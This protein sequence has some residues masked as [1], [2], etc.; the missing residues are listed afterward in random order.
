MLIL[1]YRFP[2]CLKFSDMQRYP[3][4]DKEKILM[5]QHRNHL[6]LCNQNQILPPHHARTHKWLLGMLML[7]FILLL[8]SFQTYQFFM[9][10]ICVNYI[11]TLLLLSRF[12]RVWPL[13][14]PIDGSPP[15][16]PVLGILQ[17]RILTNAVNVGN[18]YSI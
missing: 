12:S 8:N 4:D 14:D 16:S 17:A 2:W 10:Y 1:S 18:L 13:C 6:V 5:P 7:Y 15:G 9:S 3:T 11:Y